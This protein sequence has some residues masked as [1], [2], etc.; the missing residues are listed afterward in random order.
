MDR[1]ALP[2]TVTHRR[3]VPYGDAHYAGTLVDGAYP[4]RLFGEVA[5]ELSIIY[6][7]D[8]G[9]LAGY[10]DVKFLSPI[11]GGDVLEIVGQITETGTRSRQV[12]FTCAVTARAE[13]GGRAS[14]SHVLD[15]PLVATV[16]AGTVVVPAPVE[17]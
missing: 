6:D 4:L 9:L 3:Y 16:A 10:K 5:T 13:P 7:G 15:T 14:A 17:G 8:E 1:P 11:R 12:T 2:L